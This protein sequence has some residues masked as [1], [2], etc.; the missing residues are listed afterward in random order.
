MK[1]EF[2]AIVTTIQE[3]TEGL[4][5]TNSR[6]TEVG[7]K[8]IVVGDKKGPRRFS[9]NSSEF[10]SFDRQRQLDFKLAKML[11][12]NNY[13]RKNLGYLI[14]IEQG[15]ACIYETD[16]DNIPMKNWNVRIEENRARSVASRGWKNI[17]SAFSRE[18]IWPRGFPLEFV[19]DRNVSISSENID[20]QEFTAPIQQGLADGSPDV[21]AI[22]RMVLDADFRFKKE[23][24]VHLGRETWSPFNSQT[25]WCGKRFSHSFIC[26]L[27][28]FS[29]D[30]YLAQFCCAEVF[31]EH[32]LWS[33]L[34]SFR[35]F[36][37]KEEIST[38][39][40]MIFEMK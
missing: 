33:G 13:A 10:Y 26:E 36:S 8:L 30:R 6:V 22:W 19:R 4:I 3:P 7:G 1:T 15:A 32:R 25:A 27:L 21:D 35:G 28:F 9:L 16:D 23:K 31:V 38:I 18:L 37:E 34:S 5:A 17:Y 11:P 29:N 12:P 14:A 39:C 24:S 20:I 40:Y 2:A